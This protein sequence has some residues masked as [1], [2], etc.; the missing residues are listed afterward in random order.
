MPDYMV[1]GERGMADMGEMEMALPDNTAPMMTGSGPYGGVEMG[2]MFSILKVR[3][4]QKPG[5]Y[6]DPG[7]YPQPPGTRAFEW[8]GAL[9]EPARFQAEGKGSMPLAQPPHHDTQVQ[10]RKPM[11]T[12]NH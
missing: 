12:M 4:D 7:W 6:K 11:G 9:P 8:T 10:V 3:K 5:D 1:M 2:G